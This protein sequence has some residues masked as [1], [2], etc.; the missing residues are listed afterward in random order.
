[1]KFKLNLEARF[2]PNFHEQKQCMETVLQ[3][4][5]LRYCNIYANDTNDLDPYRRTL[6]L[7]SPCFIYVFSQQMQFPKLLNPY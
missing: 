2:Y 7:L 1:M 6:P 3:F 4:L 5:A